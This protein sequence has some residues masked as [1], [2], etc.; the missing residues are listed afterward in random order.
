MSTLGSAGGQGGRHVGAAGLA[1][2]YATDKALC[3]LGGASRR[4]GTGAR[5]RKDGGSGI[6]KV[7]KK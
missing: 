7:N 1:A 4:G 6:A 3:T 2:P 5:H